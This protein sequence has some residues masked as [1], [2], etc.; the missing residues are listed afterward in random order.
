MT[1]SIL[2]EDNGKKVLIGIFNRFTFPS[3]PAQTLPWFI[4]AAFENCEGSVEFTFNLARSESQE[5]L[6]SASGRVD[7]KDPG[8][9]VELP[10]LVPPVTFMRPGGYILTFILDGKQVGAKTLQVRL[11]GTEA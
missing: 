6:F 5:V 7:I 3:F 8:A 1:D 11:V 10:L 4:Y 2:T 9:G